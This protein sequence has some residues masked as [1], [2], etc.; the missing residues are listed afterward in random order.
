MLTRCARFLPLLLGLGLSTI[1]AQVPSSQSPITPAEAR[2]CGQA[3][4][5]TE[6]A[7]YG[8]VDDP[9]LNRLVGQI[10]ERLRRAT[11]YP[12]LQIDA[13][14]IGDSDVNAASMPGGYVVVNVGLLKYATDLAKADAPNDQAVQTQRMTAY[15]AAVLGHELAHVTLGHVVERLGHGCELVRRTPSR[16]LARDSGAAAVRREGFE[17]EVRINRSV[18]EEARYSQQRE[19]DADRVGALYLL[20]AG[21]EIQTAMDFWR[22]SDSSSREEGSHYRLLVTSYLS[23]H[24]RASTREAYLERFRGG[25]KLNQS[26]YDDA[27]TL[28]RSNTDLDAA[29]ALLDT[30]LTDFPD[31]IE[32]RHAHAAAYHQK[33]LN[34]VPIQRQQVRGSLLTYVARFL[35]GI[36]GAPGDVGLLQQ[37]ERE[38]QA[39][40]ATEAVPYTMSNLAVLEAYEG[41]FGPALEHAQRAV[42]DNQKIGGL[43]NNLGVV[44]FLSGDFAGAATTFG[45]L[46]TAY[47][48]DVP[49]AY[50]F[51]YGRA[52]LA[53]HDP[54]AP[55]VL[56]QY[57][58]MDQRS[59][60][61]RQALALLGRTD[62]AAAGNPPPTL[63]G[64]TLGASYNQV[65]AALGRPGN[66][67]Q[68]KSGGVLRYATPGVAVIYDR[69]KGVVGIVLQ[70][71]DAGTIE[72]LRVGD[73]VSGAQSRWGK[74]AE[75]TQDGT[76]YFD[77]GGWLVAVQPDGEVIQRIGIE[78]GG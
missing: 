12:G 19:L 68:T 56:E 32:A 73:A 25:L 40:L 28:I 65:V 44:Q 48:D 77:R 57:L 35:P 30:V 59:D 49:A 50:V 24:P 36:R 6:V 20:R 47:G 4:R 72:G 66:V 69:E 71:R 60:W 26:R 23:S 16:P 22:A 37:A 14:I 29:I 2:A 42:Q 43:R 17:P 63:V 15:V 52:L 27:L 78:A 58:T 9:D 10:V 75:T 51:N 45:A 61:R 33:W 1:V 18:I 55:Q 13:T 21:W 5:D 67:R 70:D 54:R 39:V 38:Y 31:L 46:V 34:T 76:M 41:K 74:P 7:Y 62:S 53:A 8:R 3:M 11:A 64:L